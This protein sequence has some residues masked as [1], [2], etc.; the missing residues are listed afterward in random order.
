MECYTPAMEMHRG[1]RKHGQ[2]YRQPFLEA[3]QAL[4]EIQAAMS[5]LPHT[6]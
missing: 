4:E 2:I 5:F 3:A 6:G 1:I